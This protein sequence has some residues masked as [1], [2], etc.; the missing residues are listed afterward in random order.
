ME[1]QLDKQVK[2]AADTYRPE[3]TLNWSELSHRLDQQDSSNASHFRTW[4]RVA[5]GIL[6]L[7]SSVY[8]FRQMD[9]GY[10]DS[11][12]FVSAEQVTDLHASAEPES[13]QGFYPIDEIYSAYRKAGVPYPASSRLSG[14][15]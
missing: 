3:P 4:I 6:L 9:A 10:S 7:L 2:K 5:A 8:L 12:L 1:N 14:L 11:S 13:M 15:R